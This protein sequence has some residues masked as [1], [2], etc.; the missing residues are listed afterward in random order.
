M[1][2]DWISF[3]WFKQISYN[4]HHLPRVLVPL[5]PPGPKLLLYL[6]SLKSPVVLRVPEEDRPC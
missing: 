1:I 2:I 4:P 6:V 3:V 5:Q